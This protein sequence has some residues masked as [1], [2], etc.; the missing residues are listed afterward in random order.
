MQEIH[1]ASAALMEAERLLAIDGTTDASVVWRVSAVV[2]LAA[3]LFTVA[4]AH[5]GRV[6]VTEVREAASRP[7]ADPGHPELPNWVAIAKSCPN[8][9]LGGRLLRAANLTVRQ[10]D[11]IKTV[12]LEVLAP[13][14]DSSENSG[15]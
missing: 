6:E 2:P 12:M 15:E 10:R 14:T 9:M 1:D 7:A 8:D 11:S 4:H 13:T 3:I 5:H